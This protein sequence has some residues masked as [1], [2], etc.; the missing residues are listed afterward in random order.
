[1]NAS[2][3]IRTSVLQP[4]DPNARPVY[5]I[6]E[7][8]RLTRVPQRKILSYCKQGLVSP[9]EEPQQG[10]IYF[11]RDAIRALRR[12][13]HLRTDFGLNLGGIKLIFD[14]TNQVERLQSSVALRPPLPDD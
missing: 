11:D 13:E 5:A 4:F 7:V 3:S 10:G 14:L 2:E 8:E 6:G 9:V 12:I 1:M